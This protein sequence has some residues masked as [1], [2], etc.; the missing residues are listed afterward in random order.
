LAV[1]LILV[2]QRGSTAMTAHNCHPEVL[3]GVWLGSSDDLGM[4][5]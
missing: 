1:V 5:G 2:L 4:T 3:R